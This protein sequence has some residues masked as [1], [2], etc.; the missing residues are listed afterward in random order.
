MANSGAVAKERVWDPGKSNVSGVEEQNGQK[1]ECSE[2]HKLDA[3]KT[4]VSYSFKSCGYEGDERKGQQ[5]K[6]RHR[7]KEGFFTKIGYIYMLIGSVL[8]RTLSCK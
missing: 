8:V 1:A 3:V 6:A 2:L 5:L 4:M 7:I